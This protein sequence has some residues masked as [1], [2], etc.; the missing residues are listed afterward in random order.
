MAKKNLNATGGSGADINVDLEEARRRANAGKPSVEEAAEQTRKTNAKRKNSGLSKDQAEAVGDKTVAKSAAKATLKDTGV[1]VPGVVPRKGA[2]T[3]E[4]KAARRKVGL[5][6][7][8]RSRSKKVRNAEDALKIA[9]INDTLA[10]VIGSTTEGPN[11]DFTVSRQNVG[12]AAK[13]P[14]VNTNRKQASE[15]YSDAIKKMLKAEREDIIKSDQ[16]LDS[17]GPTSTPSEAAVAKE[18]RES[19]GGDETFRM[20]KA[21]RPGALEEITSS[22]R[23]AANDMGPGLGDLHLIASSL[24][25]RLGQVRDA[26]QRTAPGAYHEDLEHLSGLANEMW[27]HLGNANLA[28]GRGEGVISPRVKAKDL[29]AF[30][31]PVQSQNYTPAQL[32]S[33]G[34]GGGSPADFTARAPKEEY[35]T[36]D[37]D[38]NGAQTGV[39]HALLAAKHIGTLAGK[40]EDVSRTVLGNP[41]PAEMFSEDRP[42]KN[43]RTDIPGFEGVEAA[44]P[45]K[46]VYRHGFKNDY[47]GVRYGQAALMAVNR[48]K[49][50]DLS[51]YA[52]PEMAEKIMDWQHANNF[53]NRSLLVGSKSEAIAKKH[54]KE[55]ESMQQAGI[56]IPRNKVNFR[57]E[58]LGPL[59]TAAFNIAT[60]KQIQE[61]H[62]AGRVPDFTVNDFRQV[63]TPEVA[64]APIKVKYKQG[65]KKGVIVGFADSPEELLQRITERE[66]TNRAAQEAERTRPRTPEELKQAAEAEKEKKVAELGTLRSIRAYRQRK[67]LDAGQTT[68][69]Y[70]G[71]VTVNGQS[72]SPRE[73]EA[74]NPKTGEKFT[75]TVSANPSRLRRAEEA[76]GITHGTEMDSPSAQRARKSTEAFNAQWIKDHPEIIEAR[77]KAAAAK[78]TEEPSVGS[79]TRTKKEKEFSGPLTLKDY[80][81]V[82][83]PS[84]KQK[85]LFDAFEVA[86]AAARKDWLSWNPAPATVGQLAAARKLSETSGNPK[87]EKAYTTLLKKHAAH[88]KDYASSTA[89]TDPHRYLEEYVNE[90]PESQSVP[91]VLPKNVKTVS[92]PTAPPPTLSGSN[93]RAAKNL[94]AFRGE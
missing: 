26:I 16:N 54:Q 59:R 58:E 47:H 12:S 52:N 62:K 88:S 33:V 61:W 17:G 34:E 14:A 31:R 25:H 46:E 8:P 75:R 89:Y 30:G 69:G 18:V 49:K 11:G 39:E 63:R 23:K 22:D 65:N 85:P 1:L 50:S 71:E 43:V 24:N 70:K 67:G 90:R 64:E 19:G 9:K 72:A 21:A 44:Y 68:L 29:N 51:E 28:H 42:A 5:V 80:S 48:Y 66:K 60:S 40:L 93:S 32:E 4:V 36:V 41:I 57:G 86:H 92:T 56:K 6:E 15:A 78:A 35:V 37:D 73:V 94:A 3:D 87:D 45:G 55:I 81:S 79:T 38:V 53:D 76:K 27:N 7:P 74:T 13:A 10:S 2:T 84:A 77:A 83:T 91:T 82:K 20:P